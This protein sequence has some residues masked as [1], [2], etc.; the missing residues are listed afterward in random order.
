LELQ[1]IADQINHHHAQAISRA[2][3]AIQHAKAAGDLL[4][5]QKS[6]LPHGNFTK[7]IKANLRVSERQ[8]Q[9]YMA[10]AQGKPVP[11]RALARRTDTDVSLF[12]KHDDQGLIINGNWM[13]NAGYHYVHCADDATYWVVPDINSK[14][15]HIS[16]LYQCKRD[17]NV[18][19]ENFA[20]PD[21][22]YDE[23]DWDGV[24]LYDGTKHAVRKDY[25]TKFLKYFGLVNPAL[26]QW[27]SWPGEGCLRPFS[28]PESEPEPQ[29]QLSMS[30]KLESN[31]DSHDKG[32]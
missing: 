15:F 3:S 1:N 20:N 27:E 7:W 13:P 2:L 26:I 14:G 5:K 6:T 4:L 16:K 17:S 8:A 12:N 11:I 25:V 21:D 19:S 22:P 9:R 31:R 24:S 18:T 32:L 30:S 28:E 23:R 29:H 10:V